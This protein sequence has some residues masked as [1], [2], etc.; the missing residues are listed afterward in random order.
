MSRRKIPFVSQVEEFA[1]TASLEAV[2]TVA[3][4]VNGVVRRRQHGLPAGARTA[5]V[6][7][8]A[9]KPHISS[10]AQRTE[11]IPVDSRG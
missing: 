7:R 6:R 1:N 2:Q 3:D 4:I 5:Q 10:S 11:A 9:R 8:S